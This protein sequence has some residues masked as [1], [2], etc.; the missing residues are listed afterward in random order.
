MTGA[1]LLFSET[2]TFWI[3]LIFVSLK[4]FFFIFYSFKKQPYLFICLFLLGFFGIF[5]LIVIANL[6]L[7]INYVEICVGHACQNSAWPFI[8]WSSLGSISFLSFLSACTGA[9]VSGLLIR[10]MALQAFPRRIIC[11]T[12]W[13]SGCF[14]QGNNIQFFF[15]NVSPPTH[16]QKRKSKRKFKLQVSKNPH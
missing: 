14:D 13:N 15:L 2:S 4:K 3:S 12:S 10:R 7:L 11:Y 1:I 16:W 6:V 8:V 9:L 5:L